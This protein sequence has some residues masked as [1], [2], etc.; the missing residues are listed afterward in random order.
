MLTLMI[1][2]HI[3]NNHQYNMILQHKLVL[4]HLPK[5]QRFCLD[6]SNNLRCKIHSVNTF[7]RFDHRH[8]NSSMPPRHQVNITT[9][10]ILR[11]I[12]KNKRFSTET[13]D[14]IPLI[15]ISLRLNLLNR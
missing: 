12:N 9:P 10:P 5:S 3:I 15:R 6:V 13:Q 2:D 7:I 14:L 8:H 1:Y 4:V 11:N